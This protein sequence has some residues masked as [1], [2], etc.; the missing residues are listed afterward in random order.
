MT[1]PI[2]A[3]LVFSKTLKVDRRKGNH[4]LIISLETFDKVQQRRQA[5]ALAP[6][7]KDIALDFPLRSS[8]TCGDC[9]NYGDGITATQLR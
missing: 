5:G 1:H 4:P 3:G 7:R 2:Y 8:V 9:A 6:A